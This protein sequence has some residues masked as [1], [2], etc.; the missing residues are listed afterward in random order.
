MS[1]P[2]RGQRC[3]ATLGFLALSLS[4]GQIMPAAQGQKAGSPLDRLEPARI[5]AQERFPWQPEGL[6]A[7]LGQHRGRH[8]DAVRSVAYSPDG[9]L[10]ASGGVDRA[11]R[12][13]DAQTLTERALLKHGSGVGGVAFAPDGKT[14]ACGGGDTVALW[15]VSGP[16]P[17]QKLTLAEHRNGVTEVAFSPDGKL[18]AVATGEPAVTRFRE[19]VVCE[20]HLWDLSGAAPRKRAAFPAHNRRI[21]SVRFAPDGKTLVSAGGDKQ[22]K[23]WDLAAALPKERETLAGNASVEFSRDGAVLAVGGDGMLPMRLWDVTGPLARQIVEIPAPPNAGSPIAVSPDGRTVACADFGHAVRVW[24]VAN[25]RARERP[26]TVNA[27]VGV[28]ALAF[29][30]DGQSLALGCRDHGVRIWNVA[31]GKLEERLGPAALAS[32][33]SLAFAPDGKTLAFGGTSDQHVRV[34]G[35]GGPAAQERTPLPTEETYVEALAFAPDSKT[36]AVS[37]QGKTVRIWNLGGKAPEE[38]FILAG[39]RSTIL[40]LAFAPEGKM[41]AAGCGEPSRGGE[42]RL[43]NLSGAKPVEGPVLDHPKGGVRSVAFFPGG[44]RLATSNWDHGVRLWDLADAQ[45]EM[46]HELRVLP[47]SSYALIEGAMSLTA[48]GSRLAFAQRDRSIQLWNLAGKAPERGAALQGHERP[49]T[50]VTFA[51][52]GARLASSDMGGRV[53]LW[54]VAT[55]NPVRE[56]QLPGSVHTLAFAPDGRHLVTAN[57]NGTVYVLRAP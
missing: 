14:L 43:W 54:D 39:H 44:K 5:P 30:P 4:L 31:A 33:L 47:G 2:M 26:V 19:A 48:D 46:R 9:R 53:V 34:W 23:L 18:L 45:P 16:E 50:A 7:V 55:A 35:F 24:D 57:G 51:P 15:D 40:S 17:R 8:W 38:R 22:V 27:L 41:L 56:W 6:V 42:V 13:W 20:I 32:V 25:G 3:L 21:A 49:L 1:Y 28:S 12:L 52:G 29:A 36:L 10:V 37:G 11:V